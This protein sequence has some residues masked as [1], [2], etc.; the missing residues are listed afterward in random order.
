MMYSALQ[1]TSLLPPDSPQPPRSLPLSLISLM[2]N[3]TCVATYLRT[4]HEAR[5]VFH[6]VAL[7]QLPMV[8]RRLDSDERRA[9]SPGSVYVWEERISYSDPNSPSGIERWTDSIRWGPSRVK[10]EF[11]FY[12]EKEASGTDINIPHS[13]FP[14]S[15]I[16][17]YPASFQR[18][19]LIK[20]TFSVYVS[21]PRGRRKWHLIAYFTQESMGSLYSICDH[22]YY[23]HINLYVPPG[24][25]KSARITRPGRPDA[26]APAARFPLMIPPNEVRS[27]SSESVQPSAEDSRDSPVS[28]ASTNTRKSESPRLPP[29]ELLGTYASPHARHPA[30]EKMIMSFSLYDSFVEFVPFR[31]EKRP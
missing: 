20:Q 9:I 26:T 5:I 8:T 2:Q 15:S 29:L 27:G 31:V 18:V 23:K 17:R 30:D 19:P 21:T 1:P 12:H 6:A 4:V 3:P 28:S 11:L 16:H 13:K 14:P 24:M 10:D 25:Y 7:G 22:P